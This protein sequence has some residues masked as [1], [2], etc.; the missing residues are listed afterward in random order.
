MAK[1]NQN[2]DPFQTAEKTKVEQVNETLVKGKESTR[3][4]L[5]KSILKFGGDPDRKQDG[6]VE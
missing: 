6:S 2:I 1:D 4:A 3:D 5:R